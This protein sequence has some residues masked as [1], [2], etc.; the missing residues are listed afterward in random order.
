M[1]VYVRGKERSKERDR[2]GG[3]RSTS[4]GGK[5]AQGNWDSVYTYYT[6]AKIKLTSIYLHRSLFAFSSNIFLYVWQYHSFLTTPLPLHS[7]RTPPNQS[8]VPKTHI[9]Q[10]NNTHTQQQQQQLSEGNFETI[11][12]NKEKLRKFC[13]TTVNHAQSA[14]KQ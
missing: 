7:P 11:P 9:F 12:E 1:C 13:Q 2:V 3:L 14:E 4:R 6:H 8:I 5:Q 10:C